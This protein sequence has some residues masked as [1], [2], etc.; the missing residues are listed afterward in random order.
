MKLRRAAWILKN[1]DGDE[2]PR[3]HARHVQQVEQTEAEVFMRR[4]GRR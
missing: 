2:L 1:S 4:S 3:R